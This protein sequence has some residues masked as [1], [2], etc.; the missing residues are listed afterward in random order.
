MKE[1]DI[2]TALTHLDSTDRE[3]RHE[4][5]EILGEARDEKAIG[6][7]RDLLKD[8]EPGI[9]DAAVNALINIGGRDVACAVSPLLYEEDPPVRNMAIEILEKLDGDA[10]EEVCAL[11]EVADDDVSKFA[12]DII[13]VI[14]NAE[15][16]P[17]LVPLLTHHNPNNRASAAATLGKIGASRMANDLIALLDDDDVWV[18]FSVLEALGAIGG[19]DI[20]S[21]LLDIARED[22]ISRNA[23]LDAISKTV[24]V[25]YY[26]E[27]MQVILSADVLS[28]LPIEIVVRFIEKFEG[29][30]DDND[31]KILLN[32]VITALNDGDITEKRNA[33]RGTIYLKDK[34]VIDTLLRFAAEVDESDEESKD[35]LKD[36]LVTVGDSD[37]LI[38]ALKSNMGNVAVFL[39]ALGEI[40]GSSAEKELRSF[41]GKVDRE[42]KK[43]L[44]SSLQRAGKAS[45]FESFV[46]ALDDE[47]G[48]VRGLAARALGEIGDKRAVPVLHDAILKEPYND[49]QETMADALVCYRG[50]GIEEVFVDIYSSAKS[51]LRVVAIRCLAMLKTEKAREI[52]LDAANDGEIEVK[53][54]AVSCLVDLK[55]NDILVAIKFALH[56]SNRDV[57]MTAVEVLGARDDG[58]KALVGV[59]K[60]DDLWIR[61]KA[62]GMLGDKKVEG[63][64]DALIGLLEKDEPPVKIASAKALGQTGSDKALDVLKRFTNDK[65]IYLRDAARDAF[66]AITG[67][68]KV[69]LWEN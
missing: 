17:R 28:T 5:V 55:G 36:A 6:I 46:D 59:L 7:L 62:V 29:V 34:S 65:D 63:V 39:E 45:S 44:L 60:D 42:T 23:A 30:I 58:G 31:G 15:V 22:E 53:K 57:R 54:E 16:A 64:E 4:A 69:E 32:S 47:D 41:L 61:F 24:A 20:C 10:L 48:H 18:K 49:V 8:K 43:I 9:R 19:P 25:S 27:V 2:N 37:C 38:T 3:L 11:L 35:L 67:S 66:R 1:N 50:E 51:S 13:A 26:K 52:L 21:R 56:D 68:E 14:G 12:I 40:G 33:L